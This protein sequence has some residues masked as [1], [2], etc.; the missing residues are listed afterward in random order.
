MEP[1]EIKV[2]MEE[3]KQLISIFV[4]SIQTL[5][6]RGTNRVSGSSRAFARVSPSAFEIHLFDI[7]RSI[8]HRLPSPE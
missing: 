7:L 4:K 2:A 5:E 8:I 3:G 1:R 6:T